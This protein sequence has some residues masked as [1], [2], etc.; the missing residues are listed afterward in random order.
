MRGLPSSYA[1][2]SHLTVDRLR[3]RRVNVQ[4]TTLFGDIM[5][6]DPVN[7]NKQE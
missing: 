4:K 7:Q 6:N 5:N 1:T 2:V 3:L